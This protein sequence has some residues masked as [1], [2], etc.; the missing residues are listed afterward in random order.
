MSPTPATPSGIRTFLL[1]GASLIALASLLE[2]GFLFLANVMS[3]R[4]AG[5]EH[6][7]A[8]GLALQTAGFLAS[9][10][11]LGIGM[12]ATRF[13]AEYPV[14]HPQNREFVQRILHLSVF[15]AITASLLMVAC[16]WPLAHWFYN[17]PLFFRVLVVTILTAPVFVMLDA[18]RG[19]ML[20]LSYYR[21]LVILSSVFGLTMITLMP[22]AAFKGPRWMVLTHA[23]C[24]LI[25][26]VTLLLVM[27]R[28]F[29]FQWWTASA[30]QVPILPMV[31]FGMLQLGTGTAVNLV[32]IALMALLVRYA[33]REELIAAGLMPLGVAAPLGV[34]W[35]IN[36]GLA[37]YPL[38]GFRE[39]GY[40][41]AASSIRNV[42]AGLPSLLN[43]ATLSLMTSLRGQEYGGVNRVVLINT[44]LAAFYMIPVTLVGMILMPWLLPLFF[45]LDFVEGIQPASILLSVAL[46]HMVSQ[47]GVNRLTVLK[48]RAV[49]MCHLLWI[50]VALVAAWYLV[51]P[52]G[53]TGVAVT[54]L[55]A[56][57]VA[58]LAVPLALSLCDGLPPGLTWLTLLGMLGALLPLVVLRYEQHALWHWS[59]GI[60]LTFGVGVTY[61]IWT[62]GDRLR[63][64]R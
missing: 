10:A 62:I 46:I 4:I 9:Q 64:G 51:P 50:V 21:G 5:A 29:H 22:F 32:M 27:R 20:G 31:R 49:M 44:W 56:H 39:V 15:L 53:A 35:L 54:L 3:A 19:L 13:A 28:H 24:S 26:A 25:A 17:K 23:I 60:I 6:Y 47:P 58:A 30:R 7:G 8:Y 61:L 14:G 18:V 11:S 36:T 12:V 43:Q 37:F 41:N 57:T 40:Y 48:P 63:S 55:I 34:V 33:T 42:T 38:F 2:R 1:Q 52:L 16:A 59:N 45:G